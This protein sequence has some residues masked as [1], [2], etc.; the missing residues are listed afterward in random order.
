MDNGLLP[1][2]P[3]W[4]IFF[5]TVVLSAACVEAGYQWA[6]RKKTKEKEEHEEEAPVGAMVGA[7]LGLLAFLLAITFGIAVDTFLARKHALIDEANAIRTAYR[8]AG[9]TA[10]PHRSAVRLL[11]RDYVEDR[12]HWTGVQLSGP[13]MTVNQILEQLSE[14]AI[15]VGIEMPNSEAMSLFIES[16]ND[17]ENQ[18]HLR[19]MVRER[20]R[21]PGAFWIVLYLLAVLGLGGMG[22]HC[23]ISGTV[24]SPVMVIAAF[25]FAMVI[26][27]IVDVDRPGEGLISV[28]QQA[29]IDL[30]DSINP[31]FVT[32]K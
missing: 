27:L 25:A 16:I 17:V 20:T 2:V 14:H 30:R 10:E 8:R 22:Y 18:H 9:M 12:L 31:R 15:Q 6:K 1:S 23:G 29:M 11:L 19:L 4:L 3:I 26:V 24:H 21:I 7:I 13:S 5:G 28:N 32:S